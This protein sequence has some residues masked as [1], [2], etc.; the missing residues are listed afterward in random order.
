VTRTHA[1]LV[2]I[3]LSLV[4]C[5][6]KG[7]GA[8]GDGAAGT[9]DGWVTTGG[10]GT[11]AAGTAVG[12][13][14]GSG[15]AGGG[16]AGSSDT[17]GAGGTV[18]AGGA[19]GSAAVEPTTSFEASRQST[20]CSIALAAPVAPVVV[21]AAL[22]C[23]G[24]FYRPGLAWGAGERVH[25]VLNVNG[26]GGLPGAAHLFSI[27]GPNGPTAIEAPAGALDYARVLTNAQGL[28]HLVGVRDLAG[29]S[30]G[31]HDLLR[32]M[33]PGWLRETIPPAFSRHIWIQDAIFTP[34]D[35]AVVIRPTPDGSWP[36]VATSS[37]PGVWTSE[38]IPDGLLNGRAVVD[39]LGRVHFVHLAPSKTDPAVT[40]LRDWRSGAPSTTSLPVVG[41]VHLGSIDAAA[42]E[43]GRVAIS[44]NATAAIVVATPDGT[45]TLTARE[46][47]ETQ[48]LSLQAGCPQ[49]YTGAGTKTVPATPCSDKRRGTTGQQALAATSDGNLWLA[50]IDARIDRDGSYSCFPFEQNAHICTT[51]VT[52]DRSV[53]EL[54]VA[55]VP[56][57]GAPFTAASPRWRVRI[58]ESSNPE[59]TM[60]ARGTKVALAFASKVVTNLTK[61]AR[62][63]V[64]DTTML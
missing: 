38:V 47:P 60:L 61:G 27:D 25:V 12:G 1:I 26:S 30:G 7:S 44:F 54:V 37:A 51:T 13:A 6:A 34:D 8:H 5:G 53:I 11:G 17:A 50:Y 40:E 23:D 4:G 39:S 18:G 20:D 22:S 46:V 36:V 3:T 57:N 14:S 29:T 16:A 42:V 43:A 62:M 56:A 33:S 15:M 49:S 10:A 24:A 2:A 45:G 48:R 32:P 55:R 31:S 59:V 28:P 35:R 63:V 58:D 52:A 64:L 21:D 41:D 19:A 9:G